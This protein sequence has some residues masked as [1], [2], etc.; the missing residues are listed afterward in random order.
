MSSG[1]EA[2]RMGFAHATD[3]GG[4]GLCVVPLE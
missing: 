1:K 2:G 3:K 4:D